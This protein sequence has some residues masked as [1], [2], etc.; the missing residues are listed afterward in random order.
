VV[1]TTHQFSAEVKEKVELFLYF[2]SGPSCPVIGELYVTVT[3]VFHAFT[4]AVHLL[5][6]IHKCT[7]NTLHKNCVYKL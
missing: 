3:Y 6:C 1:L 2:S 4:S 7:K 5:D